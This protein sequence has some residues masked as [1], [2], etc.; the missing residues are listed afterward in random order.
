MPGHRKWEDVK[1]SWF[2]DT[3]E[4]REEYAKAKREL[5]AA[6]Q[7][8]CR[9]GNCVIFV[10]PDSSVGPDQEDGWG[11]VDCPCKANEDGYRAWDDDDPNWGA[12]RA[13]EHGD[14]K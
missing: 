3:P 8:E 13:E 14:Y 6:W 11:P 9:Y 12:N 4:S 7:I 2:N 5:D 1:T 10:S